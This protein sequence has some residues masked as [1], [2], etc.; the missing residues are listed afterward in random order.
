M[1]DPRQVMVC[2]PSYS[3]RIVAEAVGSLIACTRFFAQIS[4]TQGVSH[5]AMARNLIAEKFLRS[6]LEWLVS[7][8]DDIA[9]TPND[10]Q[11]LMEPRATHAD[12]TQP[13]QI[14]CNQMSMRSGGRTDDGTM[15]RVSLPAD[16][17]VCAEDSYKDDT[18]TPCRQGLGF[19]RIHR[20]VFESLQKL[21]HE[22]GTARLWQSMYQGRMVTDFY[23]SGPIVSMIVPGAPWTGE[24]H[25][26]FLVCR[27]AGIIPRIE[28]RTKL[29]HV[30][31]KAYP[32]V[33]GSS[34]DGAQ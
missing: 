28:T 33:G 9:F 6:G 23:P 12:E 11:I 20:S 31:S 29:F 21:Q 7:I 10:F 22:D 26:F 16:A 18:L 14:Y 32:Y 1:I 13:T 17:I 34:A 5:V 19:V 24:D 4:I 3:Q 30:G 8:D 25:G 2:I 15:D 27:L